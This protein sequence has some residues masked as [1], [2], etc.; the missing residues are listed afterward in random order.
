MNFCEMDALKLDYINGLL[1]GRKKKKFQRHLDSCVTCHNEVGELAILA[2]RL[3]QHP[4][5]QAEEISAS[6]VISNTRLRPTS[7]RPALF[8]LYFLSIAAVLSV[9]SLLIVAVHIEGIRV[10]VS[11]R[12]SGSFVKIQEFMSMTDK[13][14]TKV[15]QFLL[16]ILSLSSLVLIPSIVEN[17]YLLMRRKWIS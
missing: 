3:G 8:W 13:G 10:W 12:L 16:L 1:S 2:A 9:L 15:F 7:K 5:P 11:S 14:E 4:R 17:L 6:L